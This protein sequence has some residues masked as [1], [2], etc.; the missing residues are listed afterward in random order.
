MN[1]ASGGQ[2]VYEDDF[3]EGMKRMGEQDESMNAV[4]GDVFKI[5]V[6]SKQYSGIHESVVG[7]I[8][9]Y[10]LARRIGDYMSIISIKSDGDL[11]TI[12]KM[13]GKTAFR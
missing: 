12:L 13:F 5:N 2:E 8:N 9:L 6:G 1:V 10:Y 4:F 11:E 3:L 7:V